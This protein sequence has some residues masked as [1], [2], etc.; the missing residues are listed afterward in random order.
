MGN[1]KSR[2]LGLVTSALE[3]EKPKNIKRTRNKNRENRKISV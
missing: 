1:P 2:Y 3:F